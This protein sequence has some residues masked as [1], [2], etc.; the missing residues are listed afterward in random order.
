MKKIKFTILAAMLFV[1]GSCGEEFLEITPEDALTADGFYRNAEEI[2]RVTGAIYGQSWFDANDKFLWCAG[3]GM[4]GDLYQDYQ[5]EGQLFFLS[6]NDQ[7]SI[8]LQ[9]WRGM[10]RV[11]GAANTVINGMPTIASGY[12]VPES[13]INA[14]LAEARFLRATA[15][16]FLTEF[17]GDVPVIYNAAENVANNSLQ[18][19]KNTRASVYQFI[20]EDLEFAATHLPTSDAPGR[21]TSWSAK[22]MLAKVHLTMAQN[23]D[24]S[25]PGSATLAPQSQVNFDKAKQ[26]ALDV[27]ENSGLSLMANYADLFTIAG[28]NNPESLFALQWT[29]GAYGIGSSRQAVMA[30]GSS[31]T[32][33][34]EGWG[35]FKSATLSFI[36]NVIANAGNTAAIPNLDKRRKEIY[37]WKGDHYPNIHA[38]YGGYTYNIYYEYPDDYH[39]PL[40]AGTNEGA[41][42]VLNNIKKYVLGTADDVGTSI[43]NQAVPINQYILRLADVYLIYAEAAIGSGTS[44][45]DP[46]ALE[47]YY[48]VRDRAVVQANGN[49]VPG[50]DKKTNLTFIDIFNE[51]R[52]EFGLEGINWFDVKRRYYRN[53]DETIAYLNNERRPNRYRLIDNAADAATRNTVAAYEIDP[54]TSPITATKERMFL[55]IPSSEVTSNPNLA[56]DVE[57]IDFFE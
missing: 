48:A 13:V 1:L 28:N 43:S 17:W 50:T 29:S 15:Y 3:D 27:I 36:D 4:P 18:P 10:Y 2:R 32:G 33:I 37:M 38:A 41:A 5:D 22:G 7:N 6:F 39:D 52:V 12:G 16:F 57:P 49:P 34:S 51:R 54:E 30:R 55:P 8:I 19:P 26:Y 53:A 44:T 23:L 20:I 31:L 40:L 46:K 56:K 24:T 21:V 25:V 9:G 35:G 45:T 11:I 47:Y 42:P 14:G